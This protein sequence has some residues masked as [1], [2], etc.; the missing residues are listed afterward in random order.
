MKQNQT[1]KV[2]DKIKHTTFSGK[3]FEGVVTSIEKSYTGCK[4]G[5]PVE[6][7]VIGSDAFTMCL[8]N[9]K[10]CYGSQVIEVLN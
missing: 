5:I 6:S 8:D 1:I 10:W 4:Y 7:A 9:G 3:V 2:G